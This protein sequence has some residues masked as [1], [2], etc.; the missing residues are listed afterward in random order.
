MQYG[1]LDWILEK[2]KDVSGKLV[3]S[4]DKLVDRIP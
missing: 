3:K 1:I 4:V 2:R